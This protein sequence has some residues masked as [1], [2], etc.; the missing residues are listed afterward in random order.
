MLFDELNTSGWAF[1][2][3][4]SSRAELF[5]LGR[6]IGVPVPS[7]NGEVVKEIRVTAASEAPPGSQSSLYGTGPFPLHTDTVFW[8]VPVR[9]VVLRAHGDLRR[10]TTVMPFSR[11]LQELNASFSTL[12][13]RSVWLAGTKS[14]RF[15]C[16]LRFRH[17]D[18]IGWRYDADLMSP[19][20]NAA[21]EVDRALRPLVTA[22]QADCINW[23]ADI[24]VVLSNWSVLHGRGS[25]PCE[26]GARIIERLYVR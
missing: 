15:Y 16:S 19:V 26:E 25:G 1:V 9:Y 6:A 4:I 5:E 2:K 14:R 10:P 3:G 8:P 18:S 7:P 22:G 13:E 17:G 21:V 12:M 24:A 11:F 23:S 20:N